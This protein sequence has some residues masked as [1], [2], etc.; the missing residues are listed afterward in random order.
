MIVRI[1]FVATEEEMFFSAQ[2][3]NSDAKEADSQS[4]MVE[5]KN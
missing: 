3:E 2:N 4:K 5:C 1:A